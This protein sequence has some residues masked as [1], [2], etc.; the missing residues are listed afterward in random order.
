MSHCS[1][2]D[3]DDEKDEDGKE[4][5][6]HDAITFDCTHKHY[7]QASEALLQTFYDA[8]GGF[9]RIY[10]IHGPASTTLILDEHDQSLPLSSSTLDYPP[11]NPH[12]PPSHPPLNP[13]PPHS[14]VVD[15]DLSG[16]KA[17]RALDG[18]FTIRDVHP[19][20]LLTQ[21]RHTYTHVGTETH[22]G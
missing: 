10:L 9:C 17:C 8:N 5:H 13:T 1:M 6:I 20:T 18:A 4:P 14:Y 22:S 3:D 7:I 12:F 15:M 21:V 19:R 11:H 16:L 2:Q